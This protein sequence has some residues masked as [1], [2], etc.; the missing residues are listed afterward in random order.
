MNKIL[1]ALL[2]G[3]VLVG[4]VSC[5][6]ENRNQQYS[7]SQLSNPTDADSLMFYFGQLRAIKFWRD[8]ENDSTLRN[9]EA[10]DEYLE[11][12]KE[13]MKVLGHSE[14]YMIG[15]L[16]GASHAENIA[17]YSRNYNRKFNPEVMVNSMVAALNADSVENIPEVRRRFYAIRNRLENDRDRRDEAK[18]NDALVKTAQKMGMERVS[19]DLWKKVIVN[20]AGEQI[21][22]GD[23]IEVTMLLTTIDGHKIPIHLPSQLAVGTRMISTV[24][25]DA[26]LSMRFGDRCEF[27]TTA[28]AVFGSHTSQMDLHP[29]SILLL[30][31]SVIGEVDPSDPNFVDDGSAEMLLHD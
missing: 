26:I 15:F 11:G 12:M 7:L 19:N 10:R 4:L 29:E 2:V 28:L 16:D 27:A 5:N 30:T 1:S 3:L 18:A 13:A 17:N 8:A 14:A 6:E 20:G 23:R 21:E 31:I 25:P 22:R 24:F 9:R